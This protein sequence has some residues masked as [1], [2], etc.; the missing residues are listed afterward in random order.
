MKITVINKA[1]TKKKPAN[2]CPWVVDEW[3]PKADT[4]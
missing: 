4:K 2:Y 3:A 1:T